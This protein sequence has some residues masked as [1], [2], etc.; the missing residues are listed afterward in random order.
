M[1]K[2]KLTKMTLSQDELN[3]LSDIQKK[4][5]IMFT[6]IIRD[7]NLLQKCLVY[8]SNDNPMEDPLHSANVTISFFFLKTLISKIHEMWIF[9][10]KNKI[11]EERCTF[12]QEL[13][14][15]IDE[16]ISFFDDKKTEKIF[17]FI[18]NKF[19][20]HYEYW[21]DVDRLIRDALNDLECYEAWLSSEDSA[22]EIFAST[23]EVILKVIFS[24]MT[25]LGFQGDNQALMSALFDLSLRGARLFQE[26]STYYLT[27]FSDI[28]WEQQTNI[29]IDVPLISDVK[30]PLIVAR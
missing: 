19:G 23:N 7:L 1:K 25:I 14:N 17:E 21:N 4:R 26:F 5:F 30:L 12:S 2:I 13:K 24:K 20:F 3:K 29:D 11:I 22:N 15:K 28:K 10:K 16:I 6:C 9:L 8:I 18:R 27:E